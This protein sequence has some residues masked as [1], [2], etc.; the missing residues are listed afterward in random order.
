MTARQSQGEVPV[1]EPLRIA[2]FAPF[3]PLL[4]GMAELAKLVSAGL[5]SDG[6][7]VRRVDVGTGRRGIWSLAFLYVKM[8]AAALS[9]DI[10]QIISG[11]G[12]AMLGK[13]LPGILI[14]RLLGRTAILDFVGG[15]AVDSVREWGWWRRLP[16]RLVH[17][18]VVP[19]N[20]FRDALESAHLR[21]NFV[22]IPHV[23]EIEPF[24]A[25]PGS[26]QGGK[27]I[28]FAAKGLYS[29]AGMDLLI[30]AMSAIR[31]RFPDCELWI[32][33][34]GPA[35]RDL[36]ALAKTEGA[37]GVR[38]LGPV[39][40]DRIPEIMA[41]ASL[42]V[43]GTRYESFG[44][45]LVEAMAAGR[46]VVAFSV[47]GIPDVV[48]DG[49]TGFLVPYGDIEAFAGRVVSLLGDSDQR[50]SMGEQARAWSRRF[51]W[52]EISKHWSALHHAS[53]ASE[54]SHG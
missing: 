26:P 54:S 16:F 10:V 3:P 27:R 28:L 39:S 2:I 52:D 49:R 43:H 46:P 38:F 42:F 53:S 30:Q 33:G 22:V 34:E 7:T 15:A 9:S 8:A 51:A 25:L 45:V 47:G 31:L 50:R 32:A 1:A 18:A 6:H 37:G 41:Q 29:Y 5:E 14:A 24:L 17:S 20:L 40:H 36:E 13:D 35:R 23:V 19:T 12:A 44:L 11:S 4:G 21:G 48:L